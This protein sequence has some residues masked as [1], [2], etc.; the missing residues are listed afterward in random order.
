MFE[1]TLEVPFGARAV[2]DLPVTDASIVTID[3][4]PASGDLSHGTHRITVT[5]P[6]IAHP[7]AAVRRVLDHRQPTQSRIAQRSAMTHP[8]TRVVVDAPYRSD[9]VASAEPIIGWIT[10]TDAAD[11]R[12]ARAELRAR[13]RRRVRDA[14]RRGLGVDADRLAVRAARRRATT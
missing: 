10:E 5:A 14:R 2:L 3:G 11:W 6:A 8:T 1:A 4:A 12:Q 13:S 9:T 7:S